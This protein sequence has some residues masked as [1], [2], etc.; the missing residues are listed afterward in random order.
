[1]HI[2]HVCGRPFEII[3]GVGIVA[4]RRKSFKAMDRLHAKITTAVVISL[5]LTT[6]DYYYNIYIDSCNL[7]SLRV[8]VDRKLSN[9]DFTALA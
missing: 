7:H 5:R 6:C 9:F 8:H 4:I 1:M 3:Y 2:A